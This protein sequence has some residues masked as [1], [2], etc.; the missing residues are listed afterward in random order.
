MSIDVDA[1]CA[2]PGAALSAC[3]ERLHAAGEHQLAGR[4]ARLR[5]RLVQYLRDHHEQ[6]RVLAQSKA[7]ETRRGVG[8]LAVELPIR[9]FSEANLHEH[10]MERRKRMGD[11]RPTV[12]MAMQAHANSRG[13]RVQ[14]PCTVQLTRLAP[15]ELDQG[16]NL[17][18]SLKAVRD[19]VADWLGVNDRDPRVI[20]IYGQERQK[21]Y[22]VRIEVLL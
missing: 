10:H 16:D 3:A 6:Q 20:W 4:I 9:T 22:G 21:Q 12:R 7:V 11:Q 13:L 2:V 14:P 18:S 8:V 5:G 19:G 17:E 1:L 15:A